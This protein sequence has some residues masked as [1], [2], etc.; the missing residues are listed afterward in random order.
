MTTK[1]EAK[2]RTENIV[3]PRDEIMSVS[4]HTKSQRRN[5]VREFT[6]YYY[7]LTAAKANELCSL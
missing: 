6:Y 2:G 4:L 5:N 3:S 1:R 7:I